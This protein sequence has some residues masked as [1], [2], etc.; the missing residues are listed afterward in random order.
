MAFPIN[1]L[2]PNISILFAKNFSDKKLT[3]IK[4]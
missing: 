3:F 2:A 1:P 4:R